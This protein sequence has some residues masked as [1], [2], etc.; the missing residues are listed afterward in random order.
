LTSDWGFHCELENWEG[1]F[2]DS[3]RHCTAQLVVAAAIPLVEKAIGFFKW[4]HTGSMPKPVFAVLP[5]DAEESFLR[6]VSEVADDFILWPF[7]K[8][9]LHQ[10]LNRLLVGETRDRDF[11][12]DGLSQELGLEQLVGRD[13]AFLRVIQTLPLIAKSEVPVLITGETGTGKELCARAIHHLSRRRS[14]PFIAVDCSA[15][16]DHLFENELFGHA[17]GAYTDAH[18]DQKGLAAMADR[19]TLFLDEIDSLSAPAQAK[20]LRFLQERSY[21]PLGAERYVRV[22]VNVLAAANRDMELCVREKQFRSD[23]YFRI[24]VMRLQ[25]PPLRERRSDIEQL[26]RHFLGELQLRHKSLRKSFS[27]SA[28]AKLALHDWPGNVRELFNVVQR[29]VVLCEGPH[30]LP[31]HISLPTSAPNSELSPGTFR[32][33]RAQVIES[34]ERSYVQELLRRHT[35]NV[36]R[37]ARDAGKDRRAFGRLIKKYRIDQ[38]HL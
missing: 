32:Q 24:N 1:L 12:K 20:L 23:L 25:L 4:L 13:P 36:T 11:I 15:I 29:A 22:D 31:S 2:F 26:A 19:G 28:L 9:E 37:A 14:F 34:F 21:K 10:R 5:G 17:R 7:R 6:T 3:L 33:V 18:L 16:P 27:V 30:I 38:R 35:G 8:E